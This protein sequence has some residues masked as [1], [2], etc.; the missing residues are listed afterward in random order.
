MTPTSTTDQAAAIDVGTQTVLLLIAEIKGPGRDLTPIAEDL[1]ITRLGQGVDGSAVMGEEGQNRTL[2]ALRRF[3]ARCEALGV[4]QI[5][6]VGTSAMRDARNAPDFIDRVRRELG[7]GV[8]VLSPQEEA[9]YS[10]LA[11]IY[12]LD[13]PSGEVLVVDVGGGSTE[14]ICGSGREGCVRPRSCSLQLGSVRLTERYMK[15]NP[16]T[17]AE[18]V[19]L[20]Q[21]VDSELRRRLAGWEGGRSRV[22][23]GMGGTFTT[24]VAVEKGL[25]P[26]S[27]REV[28]GRS[29]ARAEVR[30]QIEIY[31]DKSL[32]QRKHIRGLDPQRADVILAGALLLDRIMEFFHLST[33]TVSD[34]GLR[35]GIL[36]EVLSSGRS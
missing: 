7:L 16:S 21:A 2:E 19:R 14:F 22:A 25:S 17:K 31:S 8:R 24:L 30:R 9:Y 15:S 26:Y 13:L 23:V 29:L 18:R 28:H 33:I 32:K 1:E 4:E 6:V 11:V 5:V 34:Q 35:Y 27:P 36:Y 10:Y 12:G 3:N 20:E